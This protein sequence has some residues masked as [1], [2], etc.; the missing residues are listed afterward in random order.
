MRLDPLLLRHRLAREA[1]TLARYVARMR[2]TAIYRRAKRLAEA[3]RARLGG[4]IEVTV[5]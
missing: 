2:W 4:R 5:P 1:A 3:S